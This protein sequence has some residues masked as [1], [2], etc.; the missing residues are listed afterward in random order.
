MRENVCK[1]LAFLGCEI[2]KTI[3][4][5][6]HG[7]EALISTPGSKVKVVVIP[8]DEE[9]MIARDTREI[10]SKIKK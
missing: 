9:L 1:P 2:D 3:N 8:T 5:K 4:D 10:V 7:E 6:I